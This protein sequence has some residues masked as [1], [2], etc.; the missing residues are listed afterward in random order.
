AC[1]Y[2]RELLRGADAATA[3]KRVLERFGDPA[4]VAR[5]LWLDA[6]KGRIMSQRILVICC[7]V[8]TLISLSLM[9]MLWV[10]SVRA[11]RIAAMAEARAALE[12]HRAKEAQAQMH[13]QLQELSKAAQAPRSSDWIPVSFQLSYDRVHGGEPAR[14]F[15]AGLGRGR[16][17]STK[18]GAILRTS[19][20][21]GKVDFG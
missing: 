16:E 17:G 15:V 13:Q 20:E 8:L 7:I 14:G 19:D 21:Y 18:D 10:Q 2:R 5:R 11:Q 4:A 9:G 3:R 6:M 1:A 12:M